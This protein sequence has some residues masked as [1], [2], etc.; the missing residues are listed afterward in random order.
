MFVTKDFQ[1]GPEAT[2]VADF[3]MYVEIETAEPEKY[4][5]WEVPDIS[6]EVAA[7]RD[8]IIASRSKNDGIDYDLNGTTY[9]VSLTSEDAV[10]LMQVNSAFSLG[11]TETNLK[12]SNGISIPLTATD[13]PAFAAWFVTER[14]KFFV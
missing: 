4:T 6:G 7:L 14:N 5:T 3:D 9:K 2:I 11:L 10:G 1:Q 12:L 13:F 8:E